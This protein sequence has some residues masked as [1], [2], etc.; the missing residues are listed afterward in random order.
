MK[1]LDQVKIIL[2]DVHVFGEPFEKDGLTIIPASK[3]RGGGGGG[4]AGVTAGGDS[5]GGAGVGLDARPAGAF[6]IKAGE[7]SWVPA[8]DFNRIVLGMQVVAIIGVL[9]WRS[10][11][12]AM[13]R[14]TRA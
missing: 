1:I 10:V 9:S 6:V 3:V 11:A 8:V 5:G 13:A 2:S 12:R 4:G 14:R 7:V